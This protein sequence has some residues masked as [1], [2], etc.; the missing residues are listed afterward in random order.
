VRESTKH[1]RSSDLHLT[2]DA[3]GPF[4]A[5]TL[6]QALI[7]RIDQIE[8]KLEVE[9]IPAPE[10]SNSVEQFFGDVAREARDAGSRLLRALSG[11]R[12]LV[13]RLAGALA[14]PEP[15]ASGV[16]T[17]LR[18]AISDTLRPLARGWLG[19]KLRTEIPIPQ[20]GGVLIALNRSGWPLPTEGMILSSAIGERAR[21]RDVYVLWDADVATVP[22]VGSAMRRLGVLP[23]EPRVARSLLERGALVICFPEGGAARYKGY[24][25]RYKLQPFEDGFVIEEAR[26]A[27]AAIVPAAVVGHEESFPVLGR[28]AG[29]PLTPMFPFAGPLGLL[30]LPL[31]WRLRVGIP[32]HYDDDDSNAPDVESLVRGRMQTLIG[33][34]LAER[35]SIVRG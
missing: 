3:D 7:E 16:D 33:E 29:L 18:D 30:P 9:L 5:A 31:G 32:V 24:A 26:Q 8:R 34:M 20:R 23:A 25:E 35:R 17:R 22:A 2:P 10:K 19:L 12:T 6:R 13:V 1:A 27:N 15:D 14:S 11:P 21:R 4:D 28:I